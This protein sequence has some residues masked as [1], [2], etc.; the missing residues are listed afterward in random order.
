[1][2]ILI[3]GANRGIGLQV[4]QQAIEKNHDITVLVRSP[5][6]LTVEH[7]RLVVMQ[8]DICDRQAVSRAIKSQDA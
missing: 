3:I 6:K 5:Q 4:L 2:K 1:M 7:E 8:G